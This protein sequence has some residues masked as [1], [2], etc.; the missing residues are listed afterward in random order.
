MKYGQSFVTRIKCKITSSKTHDVL[1]SREVRWRSYK[2]ICSGELKKV[3]LGYNNDWGILKVENNILMQYPRAAKF[4]YGTCSAM[5]FDWEIFSKFFSIHNI[6]PNWLD[7]NY[8]WGWYDED[9]GGWTGCM[10]KV[11]RTKY[12]FIWLIE[13]ILLDWEG[14]GW[15][16]Y[17]KR[18]RL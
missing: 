14:W 18:L 13:S 9:L 10:G 1:I 5:S 6:E 12:L 3:N 7:C 2:E 11:W 17:S 15:Y 8:T 16:C 4:L